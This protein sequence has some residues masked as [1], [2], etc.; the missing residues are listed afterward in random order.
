M[1]E[2]QAAC[3]LLV[4]APARLCSPSAGSIHILAWARSRSPIAVVGLGWGCCSMHEI[5]GHRAKVRVEEGDD[6]GRGRGGKAA[7]G[8]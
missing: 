1:W 8:N 3:F 6:A 7:G 2:G 4:P 5:C